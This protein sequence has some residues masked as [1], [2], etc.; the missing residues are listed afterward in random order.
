MVFA[1][2][3]KNW[4]KVI[5]EIY[6][7]GKA[8]SRG[9]TLSTFVPFSLEGGAVYGVRAFWDFL[10]RFGKDMMSVRCSDFDHGACADD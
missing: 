5:N 7:L 10:L 6:L 1:H 4:P 2:T 3:Q 9:L 8:P